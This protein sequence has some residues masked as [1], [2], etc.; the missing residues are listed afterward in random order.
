MVDS[1]PHDGQ[2]VVLICQGQERLA[3]HIGVCDIDAV[4][5]GR[6]VVE[7]AEEIV[8]VAQEVFVRLGETLRYGEVRNRAREG[9]VICCW[10]TVF[11]S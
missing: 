5:H 3:L 4:Q 8:V 9:N 1:G 11:G 6:I 7:D 10:R 2:G